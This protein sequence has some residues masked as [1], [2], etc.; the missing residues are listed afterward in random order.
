MSGSRV[1]S[2]SHVA[3]PSDYGG[4]FIASSTASAVPFHEIS[5]G[6]VPVTRSETRALSG[7]SYTGPFVPTTYAGDLRHG[8]AEQVAT[9]ER[10]VTQ[11]DIHEVVDHALYPHR[12]TLPN[13]MG[14]I[15]D[16]G[17]VRRPSRGRTT[18][19]QEPRANNES[20]GTQV[21]RLGTETR[22]QETELAQVKEKI[23]MMETDITL[24]KMH[25]REERDAKESVAQV[26][27]RR[28][29]Q[30]ELA[31]KF[32]GQAPDQA[33]EPSAN[34]T[35]ETPDPWAGFL[36][37]GLS[38]DPQKTGIGATQAAA[39][40]YLNAA[41]PG[42]NEK[43]WSIDRKVS[44]ELRAFDDKWEN[45]EGWYA[46]IR[47]HAAQ[48]NQRWIQV[49]DLIESTN[50]PIRNSE[51]ATLVVDGLK[52]DWKWIS[53]KLWTFI[54]EHVTDL[55][56]SRRIQLTLGDDMNGLELWRALYIKHKGGAEQMTLAGMGTFLNFPK[57]SNLESLQGHVGEWQLNRMKYGTGISDPHLR[58]MFLGT[59]PEQV[60]SE[61]KRRV[62]LVS[63]QQCVN[64]VIEQL[65][66]YNDKRLA[67][68]QQSRLQKTLGHSRPTPTN[69][70]LEQPHPTDSAVPPPQP[71]QGY[72]TADL[73]AQMTKIEAVVAALKRT[74]P[75]ANKSGN[76]RA[77][78]G[79]GAGAGGDRPDP[80]FDG[81]WHCKIPGHTRQ[82]CTAYKKLV[83]A[84]GGRKPPGYKGAYEKWRDSQKASALTTAAALF[85]D[86]PGDDD[87]CEFDET[88][89][90]QLKGLFRQPCIPT[91]MSCTTTTTNAFDVLAEEDDEDAIV[92]ALSQWTQN[93]T[94]GPKL[95]Q[96]KKQVRKP[97]TKN[98][99]RK[100]A[101]AIN[102]GELNLPDL[103][104]ESDEEYEAVWAL[105]DTGAGANVASLKKH[106][107]GAV[108]DPYDPSQPKV[109]LS[110]ASAELIEGGGN[111]T[112]PA[113]TNEGR[114][115]SNT[116]V[117]ADVDMPILS[118][119]VLCEDDS[120]IVFAKA[121]GVILH[122]DGKESA[123]CKRRG[124]Y[125]QKLMVKKSL[126]KPQEP[127]NPDF[128]R[129]RTA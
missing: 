20:F 89:F 43:D 99:I 48:G 94:V 38:I 72:T 36:A 88:Q 26:V 3:V 49:F 13:P 5:F 115:V 37:K 116:F 101:D 117:D 27:E 79:A 86:E 44:K 19:L 106:F 56:H 65:G 47:E 121:G 17:S 111:F 102:K 82:T 35:G 105:V 63:T 12:H 124:V 127:V 61:I 4:D 59:L 16:D 118:G 58:L 51:L 2:V 83:A 52:I 104:L 42:F 129:P 93:V 91:C 75:G 31:Q 69:P 9:R 77:A 108:M 97:L 73:A 125:F 68:Q 32:Q 22:K 18:N 66:T 24:I 28:L 107:P 100:I 126:V 40:S 33:T 78:S 11:E 23:V 46:R 123:F 85:G 45:Y 70:L 7:P 29:A 96:R 62:D 84:N 80:K 95:T 114:H 53:V 21:L 1:P 15:M 10:V 98:E 39:T 64:Y 57:C 87:D 50:R 92:A 120:N 71:V 112:I 76:Q 81:C 113:V 34:A 41:M 110:T 60:Q 67:A 119:A 128:V 109:T 30:L 6:D 55:I 54:G 25:L 14:S 90:I 122:P 103:T 74:G 8:N